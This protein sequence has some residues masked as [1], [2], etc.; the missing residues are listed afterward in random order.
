MQRCNRVIHK[1]TIHRVAP[2]TVKPASHHYVHFINQVLEG[3]ALQLR[4]EMHCDAQH[5]NKNNNNYN[6][7]LVSNSVHICNKSLL[8]ISA[9]HQDKTQCSKPMTP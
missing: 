3:T 9:L 7:L 2:K 6:A 5:N 4:N 1:L 8:L